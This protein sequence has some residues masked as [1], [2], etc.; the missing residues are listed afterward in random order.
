MHCFNS[1]T[2]NGNVLDIL[3]WLETLCYKICFSCKPMEE[4]KDKKI[5]NWI[6]VPVFWDYLLFCYHILSGNFVLLSKTSDT[7]AKIF[8]H[9]SYVY[10]QYNKVIIGLLYLINSRCHIIKGPRIYLLF[11]TN[12]K[13]ILILMLMIIIVIK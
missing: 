5:R 13:T 2:S 6:C 8:F 10:F 9:R 12:Y 4:F 1:F 3:K 11:I 7:N